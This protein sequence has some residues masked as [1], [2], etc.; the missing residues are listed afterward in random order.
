MYNLQASRSSQAHSTPTCWC[1]HTQKGTVQ[2][3]FG[4][5]ATLAF[6]STLGH[7]HG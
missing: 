2:Y 7:A 4:V 5:T 1:Y 6:H 3:E